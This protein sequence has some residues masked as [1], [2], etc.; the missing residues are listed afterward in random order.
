MLAWRTLVS[1]SY[2]PS[3]HCRRRSQRA[4]GETA[5]KFSCPRG[6]IQLLR[7]SASTTAADSSGPAPPGLPSARLSRVH[8]AHA[9]PQPGVPGALDACSGA[10]GGSG[11]RHTQAA[12]EKGH[13]S[14]EATHTP[15]M[16]SPPR[17]W[18]THRS[19]VS[20]IA[21]HHPPTHLQ[22]ATRPLEV[23]V[24]TPHRIASKTV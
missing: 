19:P 7:L 16:T 22:N 20:P 5:K 1:P 17:H 23:K 4:G 18:C 9:P 13:A 6:I 14:S 24:P 12:A 21:N 15:Q 11:M 10:A 8:P 2:H 3:V